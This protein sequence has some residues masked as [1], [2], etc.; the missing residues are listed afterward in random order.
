MQPFGLIPRNPL[1]NKDFNNFA[2]RVSV[3]WDVFGKG[4]TVV[5]AGVGVFYDD[6][7]QDA[8]TGQIYENSF[9][10]GVAY[11]PTGTLPVTVKK[12]LSQAL[13]I[14]PGVPI[15]V[16]DVTGMPRQFRKISGRPISTTTT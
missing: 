14:P 15:F 11:N 3:A 6:F 2:P 1:Y 13:P 12:P 4:T 10:A 7:S 8:F 9:N 16:R 5:R